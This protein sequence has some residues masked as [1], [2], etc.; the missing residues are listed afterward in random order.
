[1]EKAAHDPWEKGNRKLYD[2]NMTL[3]RHVMRPVAKAYTDVLPR[4]V[5]SGVRNFF[6][7]TGEPGSAMNAALQG[8]PKSAFRAV[9]RFMLNTVLGFVV[10]DQAAT[11]GL[12]RQPHDFGQTL[13]TWG[14]HS[15]P[16]VMLPFFGPSTARDGIG[17]FVDFFADPFNLVEWEVLNRWASLGKIT[18]RVVDTRAALIEQGEQILAGSAD[19]YAT[20][21]SAYLQLRRNELY[22]GSAPPLPDDDDDY[23]EPYPDDLPPPAAD[24]SPAAPKTATPQEKPQ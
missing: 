16:Y 15:G 2:V 24:T 4:P 17:F 9:D 23:V 19:P 12:D 11:M 14:V 22:D 18:V 3:D 6:I 8:K 21:R 20:V 5:R 10:H 13:T 1:M 7:V